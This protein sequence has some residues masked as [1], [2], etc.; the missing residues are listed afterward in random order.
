M[1]TVFLAVFL[2]VLLAAGLAAGVARADVASG[3]LSEL[4]DY[5]KAVAR[6]FGQH[7]D[8][9]IFETYR[10]TISSGRAL[11]AFDGGD[12]VGTVLSYSLELYV[13]G[14]MMPTSYLDSVTVQP[15]HRRQG[16]LT[17]M[18]EWV[19]KDFHERGE[20]GAHLIVAAVT[21]TS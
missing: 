20:E 6:G 19:M 7:F 5:A 1:R 16:I 15:T 13:P 2:A 12:I 21:A 18:T 17:K 11:A 8:A 10:P 4:V 9:K 3:W 14:G